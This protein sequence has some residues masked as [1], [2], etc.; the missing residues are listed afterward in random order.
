MRGSSCVGCYWPIASNQEVEREETVPQRGPRRGGPGYDSFYDLDHKIYDS[1]TDLRQP[2]AGATSDNPDESLQ[3]GRDGSSSPSGCWQEVKSLPRR[4]GVRGGGGVLSWLNLMERDN[5]RLKQPKKVLQQPVYIEEEP[6]VDL[7]QLHASYQGKRFDF[8]DDILESSLTQR[9][10]TEQSSSQRQTF[11]RRSSSKPYIQSVDSQQVLLHGV[12]P[13]HLSSAL[14]RRDHVFHCYEFLLLTRLETDKELWRKLCNEFGY[15]NEC[16]SKETKEDLFR[17]G[18]IRAELWFLAIT[19]RDSKDK[20][21]HF[22]RKEMHRRTLRDPDGST[23][24]EPDH[25]RLSGIPSF[26]ASYTAAFNFVELRLD[27]V[28]EPKAEL[29]VEIYRCPNVKTL[30]LKNNHLSSLSPEI[31]K[32]ERLERLFLTN[33]Q[34]NNRSVPFTIAFCRRLREVY[35]DNNLLDALPCILLRIRTLQRVHRHGNHNYFKDTFM[36]YHT[37]INDRIMEMPGVRFNMIKSLQT[38]ASRAV[39]SSRRKFYGDPSIPP[40]IRQILTAL[41]DKKELCDACSRVLELLDPHYR[42]FT[43]KNPYLG[44]TCVP[45]QHTACSL[46]CAR[47][48]E[49]PARLEQQDSARQ[50]DW[51]YEQYIQESL[52]YLQ[53]IDRCPSSSG[54]WTDSNRSLRRPRGTD[55]RSGPSASTTTSPAVSPR[56]GTSSSSSLRSSSRPAAW[57]GAATAAAAAGRSSARSSVTGSLTSLQNHTRRSSNNTC[58]IF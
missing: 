1:E 28:L 29:P 39:F 54:G 40:R 21:I 4:Q 43:F 46:E 7:Q 32:M 5:A 48:I 42:V 3:I 57:I 20:L 49:V 38:L 26:L 18:P 51:E 37:D 41:A 25:R 8:V 35:L 23:E 11:S 15:C 56:A 27:N 30:S 13:L 55:S 22:I 47:D 45:F 16:Q 52:M 24:A 31:G 19:L 14:R 50:Q 6:P 9:R 12:E 2:A 17:P 10:P 58:G 34:L 36:F 53:D 33:N 44:N